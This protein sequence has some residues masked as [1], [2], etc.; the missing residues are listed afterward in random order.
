MVSQTLSGIF[1]DSLEDSKQEHLQ[2]H[3][4]ILDI[5]HYLALNYY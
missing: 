3:V 5:L 4:V 2:G 1:L